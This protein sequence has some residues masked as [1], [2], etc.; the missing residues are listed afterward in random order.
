MLLQ[1]QNTLSS[2]SLTPRYGL[3]HPIHNLRHLTFYPL[4]NW[5][6]SSPDG[7]LKVSSDNL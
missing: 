3:K 1:S 7:N 5:T 4:I 6:L 2:T